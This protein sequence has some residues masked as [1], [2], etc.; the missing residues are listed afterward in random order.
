MQRGSN[1]VKPQEKCVFEK[2]TWCGFYKCVCS[3]EKSVSFW[4]VN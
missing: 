4:K 1:R 3:Y 2:L